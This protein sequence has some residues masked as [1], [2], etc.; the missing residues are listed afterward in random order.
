LPTPSTPCDPIA[1]TAKR[2]ALAAVRK[3]FEAWSGRQ[4]DPQIVK[5]FLEMPDNIWRP[6]RD[7]N[8][9][10]PSFPKCS[11][12]SIL[13]SDRRSLMTL[14]A[15]SPGIPQAVPPLR[16]KTISFVTFVPLVV[17]AFVE[18]RTGH[19]ALGL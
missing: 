8:G 1:L 16:P 12:S 13:R 3:E 18:P 6:A 9:Q 2:K 19:C 11:R 10:G 4:F 14:P 17:K 7:I 15:G 5:V